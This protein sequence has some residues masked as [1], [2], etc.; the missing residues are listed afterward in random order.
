MMAG[1]RDQ[2]SLGGA[3]ASFQSHGFAAPAAP[4]GTVVSRYWWARWDLTGQPDYV[5][6]M[7]PYPNVQLTFSDSVA[8]IR[9]V[10]RGRVRRTLAGRG[11]VLGVVFRPGV[12]RRFLG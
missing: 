6:L 8:W 1:M 2:R 7:V 3:W 12:F 11:S 4:L 5:Q 9:G 10:N